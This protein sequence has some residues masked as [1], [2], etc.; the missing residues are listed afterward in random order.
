[1]G[2]VVETTGRVLPPSD[3]EEAA[4]A[5]LTET[6]AVRDGWF[7]PEDE[8]WPVASLAD[9]ASFVA[10]SVEPAS[11]V[12]EGTVHLSGEDGTDWSYSYA[13]GR[14]TQRSNQR[15]QRSARRPARRGR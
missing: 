9:L 12:D 6:M 7:D 2:Y 8:Q 13:D 10:T 5:A 4:S 3:R 15:P 1:M 14:L 11:W